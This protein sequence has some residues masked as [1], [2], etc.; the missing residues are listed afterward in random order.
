MDDSL[1]DALD[2]LQGEAPS[3]QSRN[4]F[5]TNHEHLG[6]ANEFTDYHPSRQQHTSHFEGRSSQMS[7]FVGHNLPFELEPHGE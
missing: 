4:T 3:F 2:R 5:T 1:F 7:D 6:V